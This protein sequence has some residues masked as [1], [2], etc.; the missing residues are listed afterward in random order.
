MEEHKDGLELAPKFDAAASA[1]ALA[2]LELS[3]EEL[4]AVHGGTFE[5]LII[6]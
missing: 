3:D 4:E 6:C 2:G 5:E 1:D